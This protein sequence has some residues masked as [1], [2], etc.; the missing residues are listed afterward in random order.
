MHSGTGLLLGT[1]SVANHQIASGQAELIQK[2]GW[3]TWVL[4]PL[5]QT[6][7][8]IAS[9]F[10]AIFTPKPWVML[11]WL[12]ALFAGSAYLL[13]KILSLLDM[14]SSRRA[15]FVAVIPFLVFP[16]AV[17]IY[18][19]L[20]KDG[21]FIFGNLLF[22][23]G[24]LRWVRQ[25]ERPETVSFLQFGFTLLW[26]ALAYLLVWIVRPYWGPIFFLFSLAFFILI[27]TN[28][29]WLI[30]FNG[31]FLKR[32]GI[33]WILTLILVLGFGAALQL[34]KLPR[35]MITEAPAHEQSKID[36]S[37]QSSK[38]LPACIDSRMQSL[39]LL[40]KGFV[41]KYPEAGTNIDTDII[42]QNANEMIFYLPKALGIGF[43][44]PSL[45]MGF[46]EGRKPSGTLMRRVTAFEMI[47]LYLC[48]PFLILAVWSWRKRLELWILLVWAMGGI[49]VYTLV[50]PNIGA[51]YRFRY[52]FIMTLA[53]LGVLKA[54]MLLSKRQ[55]SH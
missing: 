5:G 18:A 55:V 23:Y 50:S 52:G 40:R 32:Q 20:L 33:Y 43:F 17:I 42:F 39:A 41:V 12:A 44:T 19:Q 22:V 51:L 14:H 34:K 53:C 10:Y 8:G 31:A 15:R 9:F 26:F 45:S 13:F 35:A 21:F 25:R 28:Q 11:P 16:S 46:Q 30:Q 29:F 4:S 37:W 54:V 2:S 38:W 36:F 6:L 3:Q 27:T 48:Y 1:D 24:W 47:F 7:A 49:L